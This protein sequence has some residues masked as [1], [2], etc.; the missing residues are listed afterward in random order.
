METTSLG[1][2][3]RAHISSTLTVGQLNLRKCYIVAFPQLKSAEARYS[4]FGGWPRLHVKVRE[5]VEA[6]LFYLGEEKDYTCNVIGV[7]KRL[8]IP[9]MGWNPC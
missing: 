4:M 8:A 3:Q 1:S 9:I 7:L 2:F 6:G 5:L